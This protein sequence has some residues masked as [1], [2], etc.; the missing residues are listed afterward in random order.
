MKIN[1]IIFNFIINFV[2]V[3]ELYLYIYSLLDILTLYKVKYLDFVHRYL[4]FLLI[5]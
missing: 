4:I 2:Q 3:T 5:F 1:Y